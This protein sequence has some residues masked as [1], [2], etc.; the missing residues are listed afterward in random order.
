MHPNLTATHWRKVQNDLPDLRK[1]PILQGATQIASQIGFS[2]NNFI[3]WKSKEDSRWDYDKLKK[4]RSP[5]KKWEH[6][7]AELLQL[8][9]VSKPEDLPYIWQKNAK[10]SGKNL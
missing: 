1:Q 5:C 8:I 7:F 4:A 3:T 2:I 6:C 9:N 10:T